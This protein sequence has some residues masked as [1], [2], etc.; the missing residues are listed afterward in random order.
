MWHWP[1]G[2]WNGELG[3]QSHCSTVERWRHNS[4]WQG[5]WGLCAD[6]CEGWSGAH[7]SSAW[8]I[9]GPCFG[10]HRK[11][12]VQ[13]VDMNQTAIGHARETLVL[14]K[15]DA[16]AEEQGGRV[17]SWEMCFWFAKPGSNTQDFWRPS[18]ESYHIA[19]SQNW[20]WISTKPFKVEVSG[21]V[22]FFVPSS[23]DI[24]VLWC[25]QCGACFAGASSTT[26]SSKPTSKNAHVAGSDIHTFERGFQCQSL[27]ACTAHLNGDYFA[28]LIIV[29]VCSHFLSSL[30][31]KMETQTSSN[32][33]YL[34]WQPWLRPQAPQEFSPP[35][36]AKQ[37]AAAP[38]PT[39]S[40]FP[41][42]P[43]TAECQPK[44]KHPYDI[45]NYV[46]YVYILY[47]FLYYFDTYSDL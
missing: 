41:T 47:I 45:F 5:A 2:L 1:V 42:A 38:T 21:T 32:I 20:L 3:C 43:P 7:G 14:Q 22:P 23:V 19:K 33:G 18:I 29:A 30:H 9:S 34:L 26:V 46:Y 15:G 44:D 6:W 39:P 28:L 11:C 27:V 24:E 36:W 40:T 12:C 13:K 31:I 17:R 37:P 16:L 8:V 4:W 25:D 35:T 10:C